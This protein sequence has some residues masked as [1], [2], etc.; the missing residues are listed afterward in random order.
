MVERQIHT[1]GVNDPHILDAYRNIPREAFV[2]EGLKHIAYM[3]EDLLLGDG[4]FLLEPITHAR[5]VQ[6]LAPASEH[7]IL[8]VGGVTGYSAAILSGLVTTVIALEQQKTCLDRA[9]KIWE[10]LE[11]CN[12]AGVKGCLSAGY[13]ENAPYDL[14]FMNGAVSEMPEKLVEQLTP[15]GRLITILR[16]PE[17][18][19]GQVTLVKNMGKNEYSTHCLFEAGCPYLPGFEPQPQFVF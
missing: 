6:A 10:G 11:I 12:V 3:D 15:G 7:V 1:A 9:A 16:K 19:I 2:P 14:V 18:K 8:D 17:F 5:M 4:R 13:P